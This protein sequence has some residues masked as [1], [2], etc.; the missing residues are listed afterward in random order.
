M[1]RS[2]VSSLQEE[3]AV[4]QQDYEEYFL[5]NEVLK[6]KTKE[7][8]AKNDDLSKIVSELSRYYYHIKKGAEK[9]QEL[10][11]FLSE[12]D[13]KIEPHLQELWVESDVTVWHDPMI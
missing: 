9:V 12:P 3:Y 5:Q 4:M 11:R 6:E 8:L 2:K 10:S 13:S 7:L 1:L